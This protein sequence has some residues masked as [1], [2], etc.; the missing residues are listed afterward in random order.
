MESLVLGLCHTSYSKI[1]LWSILTAA[2]R[3]QIIPDIDIIDISQSPGRTPSCWIINAVKVPCLDFKPYVDRMFGHPQL[4]LTSTLTVRFPSLPF[5]APIRCSLFL[6]Y[7]IIPRA[8][9][10]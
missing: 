4:A 6:K 8:A 10:N 1:S 2:V 3:A 5:L 7:L 9:A